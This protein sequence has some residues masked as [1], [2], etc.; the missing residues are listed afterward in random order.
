[1]LL[2]KGFTEFL[3]GVC[4]TVLF[5]IISFKGG[6]DFIDGL[7]KNT[8]DLRSKLTAQK[9]IDPNIEIVAIDD[10]DLAE[11][12]PCPWPRNIIAE[13]INNLV[14]AGSKVIALNMNFNGPEANT[15][16]TTIKELKKMYIDLGLSNKGR[17]GET[18]YNLLDKAEANLDNDTKLAEAFKKAGNVVLPVS[19]D[20]ASAKKDKEIPDYIKKYSL[21]IDSS[22]WGKRPNKDIMWL[23]NID[24]LF[25]LF[26]ES[27][28]GI[29]HK[30]FFPDSDG[31]IRNQIH[32]IGYL[33]KVAVPSFSLAIVK[34][35]KGLSDDNIKVI[36][37]ESI[38]LHV[39]ST[40]A[41][42]IPAADLNMS[43]MIKW[44]KGPRASFHTTPFRDV[45]Y[46]KFQTSLFRDKI[47]IVGP[48]FAA[49]EEQFVTPISNNLPGVEIMANSVSNILRESFFIKPPWVVYIELAFILLFGLY[50][51]FFLPRMNL[52]AGALSMIILLLSYGVVSVILFYNS[53]VYVKTAPQILLIVLG[54]FVIALKRGLFSGSSKEKLADDFVERNK[55]L[56]LSF[57][58]QGLFDLA[59]EKIRQCPVTEPG[60]KEFLYDLGLDFEKTEQAEKALSAYYLI[61]DSDYK[62]LNERIFKL[63][64][65]DGK[66]V[67]IDRDLHPDETQATLIRIH[68]E[69]TLGKYEISGEIGRG[70][71]GVVYRGED[72]A[73]G[74]TVAI[75]TLK[76]SPFNDKEIGDIKDRFFREAESAGALQHP[77]I[78][79]M[80]DAGEEKGL[81]YIAMEYLDGENLVKYTEVE[82]LL[83][84]RDTL[85]IISQVADALD[86]AHRNGIIHRDIKPA[87]IMLLKNTNTVKVMDF[88][89]A[90]IMTSTRTKTGIV[91]GTPSYMSPE[92]V[93]GKRIDGRSDIFSA[94]VVLFEML[95]GQKPFLSDD[96]TSLMYEIVKEKH[97]SIR[98]INPKIPPI[99]EKIL[100]KALEKDSTKRYQSAGLMGE[101]LRKIAERIDQ[102]KKRESR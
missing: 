52:W 41:I 28:A 33:E 66:P 46:K 32:I 1:M 12:G 98:E 7:E 62:D 71:M 8:F 92:Q 17:S 6:G 75:K 95:V 39:N 51:S 43:T 101:H 90:R 79:S 85:H 9:R 53:N 61:G 94:G 65:I 54:Y 76:L 27:V 13:A 78:I 83:P 69:K 63:E 60:V 84:I 15:G 59:F 19:F 22:L 40:K 100:D 87:N 16:L 70:A 3:I 77:N 36:P 56:A 55:K 48:E 18:F 67:Y 96:I 4:L 57:Y 50:L 20:T 34:E 14:M 21:K 25:P 88:G 68:A 37:G 49:I 11:I 26:A 23:A 73:T 86:Y 89:I 29:G 64:G 31:C 47:V 91:L 42:R 58:K 44:S 5:L 24:P 30:N 2:N 97:P 72:P 82:N 80:L 35:F 99:I 10:K 38:S 74:A 81:A 102:L 93:S 45:F